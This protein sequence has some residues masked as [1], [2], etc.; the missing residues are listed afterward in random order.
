M[1]GLFIK[2]KSFPRKIHG[3]SW[4]T[5]LSRDNWHCQTLQYSRILSLAASSYIW[6]H[7]SLEIL[8]EGIVT[9]LY[10]ANLCYSCRKFSQDSKYVTAE[11]IPLVFPKL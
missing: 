1:V 9:T 6:P 8:P 7:F 2:V 10:I 5:L 11:K 3:H 4:L